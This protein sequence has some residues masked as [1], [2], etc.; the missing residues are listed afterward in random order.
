MIRFQGP[1]SDVAKFFSTQWHTVKSSVQTFHELNQR[2]KDIEDMIQGGEEKDTTST[3]QPSHV[4][5]RTSYID[6][7]VISHEFTDHCN[8]KTLLELDRDTPIL[9]TKRAVPLIRSWGYFSN[10]Q[11]IPFANNDHLNWRETSQ[12]L[13]PDWLGIRQIV[14]QYDALDYHSAIMM[15]FDLS[16][17]RP[18]GQSSKALPAEAIIYTPH[19]I[20][21]QDLD[22]LSEANPQITTLALLHGL[23]DIKLSVSR[24]N[25]GAHNGLKAQRICQ[26]KYWVSTHDEVKKSAGLIAPWLHR[27]RLTLQEALDVEAEAGNEREIDGHHVDGQEI[28]FANLSSGESLLLV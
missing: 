12:Q 2:L 22:R 17:M 14:S 16:S 9:A 3:C 19:G 18:L 25:L 24:L 15:T 11:E 6:V 26:A 20:H 4:K 8:K 27:K 5:R 13:L 23:H 21:A 10:V 28:T 7:V 1:Q